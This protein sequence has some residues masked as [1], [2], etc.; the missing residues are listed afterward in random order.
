MNESIN[1]FEIDEKCHFNI[2]PKMRFYGRTE[3]SFLEGTN[4]CGISV[5]GAQLSD[6]GSWGCMIDYNGWRDYGLNDEWC[7]AK[8]SAWLEVS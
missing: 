1:G 7:T 6:V 2:T 8:A 5:F 4:I 3:N